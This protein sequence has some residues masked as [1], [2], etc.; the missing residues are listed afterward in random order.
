M[1]QS[2]VRLSLPCKCHFHTHVHTPQKA[3]TSIDFCRARML[4]SVKGRTCVR[5][6]PMAPAA[7]EGESRCPLKGQRRTSHNLALLFIIQTPPSPSSSSSRAGERSAIMRNTAE[8]PDYQADICSSALR[9]FTSTSV[10]HLN[11][12]PTFRR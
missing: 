11:V 1:A 6:C 2:S 10:S 5:V 9:S 3:L 8:I 7:A 4:T 12:N